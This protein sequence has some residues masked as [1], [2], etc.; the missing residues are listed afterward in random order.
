MIAQTC[1]YFFS[2]YYCS[3]QVDLAETEDLSQ[4][5]NSM[6]T[7]CVHVCVSTPTFVHVHYFHIGIKIKLGESG[8]D[9]KLYNPACPSLGRCVGGVSTLPQR[10]I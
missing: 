2:P 7:E 6:H 3:L 4:N 9:S 1:L 5:N 8:Y 10:V